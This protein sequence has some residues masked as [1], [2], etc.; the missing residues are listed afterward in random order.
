MLDTH[1]GTPEFG[2]VEAIVCFGE[3]TV[4]LVKR[5]KVNHFDE[6]FHAYSVVYDK[7]CSTLSTS[8]SDLKDHI[9]LSRHS[10]SYE[11]KVQTYVSPR[12]LI[13]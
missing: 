13:V 7:N 10:V 9:P 4:F 6:H 8:V 5:L 11:G 12:Y 1:D 3:N 2:H